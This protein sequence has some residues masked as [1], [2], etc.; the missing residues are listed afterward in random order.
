VIPIVTLLA[1]L[2]VALVLP[3]FALVHERKTVAGKYQFIVGFLNEPAIAD[4]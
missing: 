2:L 3:A 1:A 4:R